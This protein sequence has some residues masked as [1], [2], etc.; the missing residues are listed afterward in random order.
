MWHMAIE[1]A[2]SRII[3][4]AS[5]PARGA[6]AGHRHGVVYKVGGQRRVAELHEFGDFSMFEFD[7]VKQVSLHNRLRRHKTHP[8][9]IPHGR[10]VT[11]N[12][13]IQNL[14][15]NPFPGRNHCRHEI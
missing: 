4:N 15:I 12:Q 10:V 9:A 11:I 8:G 1:S 7:E 14:M 3:V 6:L 5:G 13:D 2:F